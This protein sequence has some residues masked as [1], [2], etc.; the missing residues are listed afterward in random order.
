MKTLHSGS[1]T[2]V[3]RGEEWIRL[4][5]TTTAWCGRY[6]NRG[7]ECSKLISDISRAQLV[8]TPLEFFPPPCPQL[9]KYFSLEGTLK[10]FV[11]ILVSTRACHRV[12]TEEC[13]SHAR[14]LGSIPRQRAILLKIFLYSTLA[15]QGDLVNMRQ[16]WILPIWELNPV[17]A[18]TSRSFCMKLWIPGHTKGTHTYFR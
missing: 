13:T 2:Q 15:V 9:H 7:I 14:K 17:F 1:R 10:I 5:H 3:S 16:A 18:R 11:R 6:T 12:F 4:N 8:G